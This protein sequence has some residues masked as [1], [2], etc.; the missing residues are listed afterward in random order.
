M[1]LNKEA[2]GFVFL[3]H[4]VLITTLHIWMYGI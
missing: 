3:S 2:D 1:K 4:E